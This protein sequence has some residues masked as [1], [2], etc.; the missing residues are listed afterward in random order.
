MEKPCGSDTYYDE[1]ADVLYVTVACGVEDDSVV[2]ADDVV[3]RYRA[4]QLLGI[5]ILHASTPPGLRL[6]T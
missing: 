2:T 5:T 3:L 6:N 4:G 1:E